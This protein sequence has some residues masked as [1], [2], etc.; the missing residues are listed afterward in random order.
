MLGGDKIKQ[1]L[2]LECYS[3]ISGDMLVAA[4]IDLGVPQ[5]KLI[6]AL[7]TIPIKDFEILIT[8]VKKS[9][10]LATDFNVILK[11]NSHDHD[12]QYLHG[13]KKYQIKKA[14]RSFKEINKII[15]ETN[16]STKAKQIAKKIFN[17][18]AL[19]EAEVHGIEPKDVC[20]H[21]FK[22]SDEIIDI[23][24]IAYALDYL[25]LNE[26]VVSPLYEGSGIIRCQHGFIPVPSPATLNIIKSYNLNL[27]LTSIAGEL[28][29][30]TGAAAAAAIKTSD[31]LPDNYNIVKVGM[32]AGKR[33]Y[34]TAGIL[35]AMIIER[36][37]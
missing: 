34:E 18:L 25:K 7:K 27:H 22:A 21:S 17:I 5:E 24:A 35:R 19:A 23:I 26:V 20:F 16:I 1:I 14:K 3:G 11:E 15:E 29:T 37:D 32:G 33:K 12:M 4:L 9:C 36:K 6:K 28:V 30:P 2:Y 10:V 8:K 31:K 13:N